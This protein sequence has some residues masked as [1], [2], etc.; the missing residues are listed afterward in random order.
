[1]IRRCRRFK[2]CTKIRILER[3]RTV[4]RCT[5][6]RMKDGQNRTNEATVIDAMLEDLTNKAE[7]QP[8]HVRRRDQHRFDG[9][10][11]QA[12]QLSREPAQAGSSE[13][14]GKCSLQPRIFGRGS[15]QSNA[16]EL[17]TSS[18]SSSSAQEFGSKVTR[19]EEP[20]LRLVDDLSGDETRHPGSTPTSLSRR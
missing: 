10:R 15:R 20:Q 18:R 12:A 6:G 1:M 4:S 7:E 17:E 2:S 13:R 5:V 14:R 16:Q 11:G 8:K 19:H 3:S 9:K